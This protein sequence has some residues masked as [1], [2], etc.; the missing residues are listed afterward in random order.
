[1]KVI[2]IKNVAKVGKINEIKDQPDGYVRNFLIPKGFAI[3]ATPEAVKK[4]QNAQSE[5]KVGREVQSDLFKKNLRS[6][7]G[8][9]VT[10]NVKTN[11]KG[12]LFQSIHTRDIAEALKKQHHITIDEQFIKLSEPIKKTGTFNIK[13]EAMGMTEE[14]IVNITATK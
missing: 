4:L 5:V 8:V 10:L 6:V 2:F 9:G 11:E 3:L 12:S 1:M 7:A 14:I 13:V